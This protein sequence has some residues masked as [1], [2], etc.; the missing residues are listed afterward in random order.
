MGTCKAEFCSNIYGLCQNHGAHGLFQSHA[1]L[2]VIF[3][4]LAHIIQVCISAMS[5]WNLHH[6]LLT[7]KCTW[8]ARACMCVCY[9]PFNKTCSW[10]LHI[11]VCKYIYI[12]IF[13]YVSK[14]IYVSCLFWYFKYILYL[15]QNF[16]ILFARQ[17]FF[18]GLSSFL[19]SPNTAVFQHKCCHVHMLWNPP[20]WQLYSLF[21]GVPQHEKTPTIVYKGSSLDFQ[22]FKV[23]F[24]TNIILRNTTF[25]TK[26][27]LCCLCTH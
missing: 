1:S 16:N 17:Q 26:I 2:W 25:F 18:A 5:F 15:H 8:I 9:Q 7:W 22:R 21:K 6:I 24:F 14:F 3:L 4:N 27:L 13:K 20:F 19:G 11:Y 12:Q 10:F 23:S